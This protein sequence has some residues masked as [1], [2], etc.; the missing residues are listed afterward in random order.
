MSLILCLRPIAS[1]TAVLT[2]DERP[3][4]VTL[5]DIGGGITD[6]AI[7]KDGSLRHTAVLALGGNHFTN[8]IGIG[9]RIPVQGGREDKEKYGC[10]VTTMVDEAEEMDV[11]G[12]DKQVR[13]IPKRYIAEIIQPRCEELTELIKR[14][15]E[16][17]S[18]LEPGL[19]ELY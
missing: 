6:I 14:E 5:V 12:A 15:I 16:N 4:H 19:S 9:L 7:Y 13:K 17:G 3:R 11:A 10:A 18:G 8:D 1:A 2:E